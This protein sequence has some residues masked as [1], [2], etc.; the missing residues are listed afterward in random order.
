MIVLEHVSGSPHSRIDRQAK[1]LRAVKVLGLLSANTGRGLGLDP[2]EYGSALDRPYRYDP[3][4]VRLAVPLYEGIAVNIDHPE[5][6]ASAEGR[7]VAANG[8]SAAD[9]FGRLINVRVTADGLVADLEYLASHPLAEMILETAERMPEQLALSHHARCEFDLRQGEVVV[10][11]I[12]AVHSVDVI[13]DRPGTTRSLFESQTPPKS[14]NPESPMTLKTLTESIAADTTAG[15]T[16][17]R[18]L[19]SQLLPQDVALELPAG[20]DSPAD[21]DVVDAALRAILKT[22]LTHA[23]VAA[24]AGRLQPVLESLT[25]SAPAQRLSE[26]ENEN[27]RLQA[28]E[29]VRAEF[30][31]AGVRPTDPLVNAVAALESAADREAVLQSLAT[32]GPR[33]R[34]A[35]PL[36]EP[37]VDRFERPNGKAFAQAARAV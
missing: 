2:R 37:G 8:R 27:R 15:R 25:S 34:S 17:R 3:E 11:R 12:V 1:V 21:A 35:E 6:T 20:G 10:R 29:H 33:P 14:E 32:A 23:D 9:R 22:V 30:D 19:E 5:T 18:I 4:A 26:L 31:A 16:L 7:R 13:G 36:V 24:S 28:R